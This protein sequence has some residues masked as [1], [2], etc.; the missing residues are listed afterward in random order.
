M[1]YLCSVYSLN[2][3]GLGARK[4]SARM[5]RRFKYARDYTAQRL[6]DGYCVFSPIAHC[7]PMQQ[8]NDMPPEWEFWEKLDYQ[9]MDA[10]S[11]V[12]VLQMP[13]WEES[14]GITAEIKYA[15]KHGIPISYIVA[16]DTEG[17]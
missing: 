11:Q 9:F 1:I 7:H 8:A 5:H 16:T 12:W 14:T 15:E 3:D 4:H 17:L 2:S 10:C 6:K 13:G